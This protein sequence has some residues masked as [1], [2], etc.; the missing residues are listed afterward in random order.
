MRVF[1]KYSADDQLEGK[2]EI[3]QAHVSGGK[4]PGKEMSEYSN[5]G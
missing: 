5:R 2:K 1:R 3:F 4:G